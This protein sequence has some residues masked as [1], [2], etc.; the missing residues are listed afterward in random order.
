MEK[1]S[2]KDSGNG[3]STKDTVENPIGEVFNVMVSIPESLEIKMVNASALSDYEIWIFI[4]SIV[5]N[6]VVGFWVAYAQNS[7]P[8]KN[9]ILFWISIVF[10]VM[11]IASVITAFIKRN[12]LRSK[13][14]N[15]KLSTNKAVTSQ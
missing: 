1:Q 3:P 8:T 5:S 10:T 12:K 2:E 9:G 13:T 6:A 15:V 11:L 14:K 7:E 4:S